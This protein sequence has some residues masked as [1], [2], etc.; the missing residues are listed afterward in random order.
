MSQP[1]DDAI[2]E[3]ELAREQRKTVE[4]DQAAN[5]QNQSSAEEFD[6]VE[7]LP[8]IL[9]EDHEPADAEGSEQKRNRQAGRINGQEQHTPCNRVAAGGKKEHR[10]KDGTN[11]RSPAESKGE[12]KKEAAPDAGLCGFAAE[13]HVPIKPARHGGTEK[14]D[15]RE[16]EEMRSAQTGKQR[17]VAEIRDDTE[18]NQEHAKDNAS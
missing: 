7:I 13:V 11:T 16:R 12:A 5:K 17:G 2:K 15:E 14:A 10:T 3:A 6:G 8:K 18:S 1:E 4:K 9:V